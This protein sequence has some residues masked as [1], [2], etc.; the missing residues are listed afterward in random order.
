MIAETNRRSRWSALERSAPRSHVLDA[1]GTIL[2]SSVQNT[3]TAEQLEIYVSHFRIQEITNQL[4]V[5]EA[6]TQLHN[7]DPGSRN[8][9]EPSLDPEYDNAGR[10]T[11]TRAQRHSQALEIERH[12]LVE[13]ITAHMPSYKPPLDYRR[14]TRFTTRVFIPQS[15]YPGVNFVGQ[16]L[17]PRGSTLKHVQEE[18]QTVIAIRSKGS[19]K[20]GRSTAGLKSSESDAVPLHAT[21]TADTQQKVQDGKKRIQEIIDMASSTS[22]WQNEH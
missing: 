8:H 16:I 7:T 10:R 1:D 18:T 11:N 21:I 17:G 13:Q 9:R 3:M 5:P 22:E 12:R 4:R 15:D 14:P 20:E 2:T 19:V 6:F